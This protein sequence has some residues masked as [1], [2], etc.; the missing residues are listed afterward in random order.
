M[1]CILFPPSLTSHVLMSLR[2]DAGIETLT[3][4]NDDALNC[5]NIDGVHTRILTT[6]KE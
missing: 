6:T 1:R 2:D 3:I 4:M 5:A